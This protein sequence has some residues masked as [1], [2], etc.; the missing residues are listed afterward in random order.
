MEKQEKITLSLIRRGDKAIFRKLYDL[1]YQRLLLYARSYLDNED[2]AE[3][4][5]Q[6]I[7][8]HLYEKRKDIVIFSSLISY[9]FRSVH[10]KCIQILRHQKVMTGYEERHKLKIREAEILYNNS[11][12][13]SFSEQQIEEISQ[14]FH[15]T[16]NKLPDKTKE[17]F[18]LSREQLKTNKEIAKLLNIQVKTVEYHI[19]KALKSFTTELKDYFQ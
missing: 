18:Q 9:F 3:D 11:D 5:V 6:D 12:T 4:V 10:N 15:R 16:K 17:I 19:T 14:I 2:E 13:F 7:F 8:V 1:Y